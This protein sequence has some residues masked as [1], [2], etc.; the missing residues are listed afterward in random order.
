[1]TKIKTH[2]IAV[3]LK[4]EDSG[5]V[6]EYRQDNTV[7]GGLYFEINSNNDLILK[8]TNRKPRYIKFN[9]ISYFQWRL[10]NVAD[11]SWDTAKRAIHFV[12]DA[13]LDR[14]TR[15]AI[16]FLNVDDYT[17]IRELISKIKVKAQKDYL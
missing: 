4:P 15:I 6:R 13:N 10:E 1:M 11:L 14:P 8:I 12:Y 16:K 3:G 7:Q 5:T 9:L 2:F 17:D